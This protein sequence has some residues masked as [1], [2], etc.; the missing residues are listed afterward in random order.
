MFT[1][2][3]EEG[4][5]KQIDDRK[6]MLGENSR[7]EDKG[8]F[9]GLTGASS[10]PGL[11]DRTGSRGQRLRRQKFSFHAPSL[12]LFLPPSPRRSVTFLFPAGTSSSA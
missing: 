5:G 2:A 8:N 6:E 11:P 9:S 3:N 7:V 12:L 10:L 1:G 4:D